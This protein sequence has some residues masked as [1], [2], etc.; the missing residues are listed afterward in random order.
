MT[1]L[2]PIVYISVENRTREL[3]SKLLVACELVDRGLTVVI[4][5]Q[6]L[7][8]ENLSHMPPGI[9]LFKGLNKVQVQNMG[10]A[11]YFGHMPIS[12]DE[13]ALGVADEAF[14]IKDVYPDAPKVA[15]RILALGDV[16]RRVLAEHCDLALDRI[17]VVG[18]PRLDLLREEFLS[19][20]DAE[21]AGLQA[22]HG[23]FLLINTNS[24]GVNSTW[25][26]REE[27][28]NVLVRIGWID[29]RN[30]ADLK[31]FDE[32]LEHDQNN[33]Q[34]IIDLV[35]MFSVKDPELPIVIRPHP[36]ERPEFWLDGFK[37]NDNVT[38]VPESN[39]IPWMMAAAVVV[40]TGCTTGMEA[41]IM[42]RPVLSICPAKTRWHGFYLANSVNVQVRS[43]RDAFVV[44]QMYLKGER[45][46]FSE[47]RPRLMEVMEHY[48]SG[49]G[50]AYAFELMAKEIAA[51]CE[52][53]TQ[54]KPIPAFHEAPEFLREFER[55]DLFRAKMTVS[56]DE[57]KTMIR[58][59]RRVAGKPMDL[60][61][62]EIG[63]SLFLMQP[64]K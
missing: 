35:K 27:Y 40:N 37:G 64:A 47:N 52:D 41:Q 18:N 39:H 38:V 36:S 51:I 48:I 1:D 17:P 55:H 45:D 21:V 26:S 4:G 9:V 3:A 49:I 33:I 6:W 59:L 63:D 23:R 42:N 32:H 44:L 14:M 11:R 12:N 43:V 57:V 22:K 30:E 13:E 31:L 61:L 29:P 58:D 8:N 56:L 25:G 5:Q 24:A 62:Q 28:F 16:H 20:Y 10:V 15:Q 46:L 2:F 50:G 19:V 53:A 34:A 60:P 54:D 7:L